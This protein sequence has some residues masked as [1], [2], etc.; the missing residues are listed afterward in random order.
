M[1]HIF[2]GHIY[3]RTIYLD[4]RNQFVIPLTIA[5]CEDSFVASRSL[6]WRHNERNGVS[7][8]RRVDCLPNSF[9]QAQIKKTSKH[10]ANGPYEWNPP[11]TGGFLS[12]RTSNVE[13]VSIW[14]RHHALALWNLQ[15]KSFWME[16]VYSFAFL[17]QQKALNFQCLD[18]AKVSLVLHAIAWGITN[19]IQ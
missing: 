8:H 17:I 13:N 2:N 16:S 5:L 18:V 11:I 4:G 1:V 14:W 7:N 10:R 6:Q 9:F 15:K 3:N 12:Q 19:N